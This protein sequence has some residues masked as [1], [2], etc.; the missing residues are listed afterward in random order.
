MSLIRYEEG[1]VQASLQSLCDCTSVLQW[2][3]FRIYRQYLSFES[4]CRD[5]GLPTYTKALATNIT[6]A[7]RQ[8]PKDHTRSDF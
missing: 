3:I 7:T 8:P 1:R 6:S 2:S 4:R 5:S